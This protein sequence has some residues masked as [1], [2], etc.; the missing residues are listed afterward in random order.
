MD[1]RYT[2][3]MQQGFMKQRKKSVKQKTQQEKLEELRSIIDYPVF[4]HGNKFAIDMPQGFTN[5]L[6]YSEAKKVFKKKPCKA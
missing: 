4:I 5:I 3:M 1:N 2:D 6:T